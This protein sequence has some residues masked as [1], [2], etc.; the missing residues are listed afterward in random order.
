M[1]FAFFAITFRSAVGALSVA[2]SLEIFAADF[3]SDGTW[4]T[5][6]PIMT[7]NPAIALRFQSRPLAGRLAESFGAVYMMSGQTYKEYNQERS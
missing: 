6:Q 2:A 1:S 3:L 7:S 5:E 4:I